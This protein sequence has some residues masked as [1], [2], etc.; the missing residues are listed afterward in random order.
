MSYVA[1]VYMTVVSCEF[2]VKPPGLFQ[3]ELSQL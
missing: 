1:L 2:S 3:L